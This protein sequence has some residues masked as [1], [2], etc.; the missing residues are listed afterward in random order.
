[1]NPDIDMVVLGMSYLKGT[2]V[3]PIRHRLEKGR[4][5]S[6]YI[7]RVAIDDGTM[8][9]FC[10]HSP[11]AILYRKSLILIN[12]L[13][14]NPEIRYNEDGLFNTQYLFCSE[15][16]VYADF[17]HQVYFYRINTNSS[18]HKLDLLSQPYVDAM[19][20]VERQLLLL[21]GDNDEYDVKKQCEAKYITNSLSQL[22]YAVKAD[23][24]IKSIKT[25]VRGK[26]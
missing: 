9:G 7:K 5:A 12:G 17:S 25:I 16:N 23:S 6:D 8:S 3:E 22:M 26:R 11:C 24:G 1:M 15:Q 10:F 14:F 13:R 2:T 21:T 4:Y 18:T 20:Q 19:E